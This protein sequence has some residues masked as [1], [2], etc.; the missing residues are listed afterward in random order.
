MKCDCDGAR[1]R[2]DDMDVSAR[3]IREQIAAL[4]AEASAAVRWESV[5]PAVQRQILD[6][7][8]RS[9]AKAGITTPCGEGD[10]VTSHGG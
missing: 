8:L 4:E 9:K 3:S 10:R 7:L 1:L 2:G 5:P 6:R